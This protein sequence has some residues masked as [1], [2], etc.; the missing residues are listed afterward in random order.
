MVD[1][2]ILI[3]LMMI[4]KTEKKMPSSG[5]ICSEESKADAV[6]IYCQSLITTSSGL[7]TG[8]SEAFF[9]LESERPGCV[10]HIEQERSIELGISWQNILLVSGFVCLDCHRDALYKLS[11]PKLLCHAILRRQ[12]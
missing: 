7:T 5:T 11:G 8:I 10:L 12:F 9:E 1:S 3:A 4:A 2:I 6:Q